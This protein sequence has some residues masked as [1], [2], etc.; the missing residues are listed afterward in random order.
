MS[1]L[2]TTT[3]NGLRP[4][5]FLLAGLVIPLVLGL[6]GVRWQVGNM[7]ANLTQP[8][9]PSA[10]VAADLAIGLAPTDPVVHWLK[11]TANISLADFEQA[12]V[13]A[14]S[15]Y[16]WRIEFG[17]ALEQDEQIERAEAAVSTSRGPCSELRFFP[18][19]SSELPSSTRPSR[20][21]SRRTATGS[22]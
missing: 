2:M 11:G 8:T 6:N 16:R 10:A 19:G 9:D 14:P 15:D 5:L 22:G 7:V 1:D 12:V 4:R 20:R 18:L 21:S 17:R 13:L 3:S